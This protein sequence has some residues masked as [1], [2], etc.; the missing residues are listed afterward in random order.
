MLKKFEFFSLQKIKP[1][2]DGRK[3][4]PV[5]GKSLDKVSF[6]SKRA[7]DYFRHFLARNIV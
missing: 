1:V 5:W 2:G 4:I 7:C 6:S 3:E